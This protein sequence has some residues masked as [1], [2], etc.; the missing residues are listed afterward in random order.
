VRIKRIYEMH[1]REN[2]Q[3]VETWDPPRVASFVRPAGSFLSWK[4]CLQPVHDAQWSS[5]QDLSRFAIEGKGKAKSHDE[6]DAI[7]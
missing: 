5:C 6:E 1:K 7:H 4:E 2:P 3:N